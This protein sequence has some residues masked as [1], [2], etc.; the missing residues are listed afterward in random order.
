MI[1]TTGYYGHQ[2]EALKAL[3]AALDATVVDIRFMPASRVPGWR[4][5]ALQKLLGEWKKL[6]EYNL[7]QVQEAYTALGQLVDAANGDAYRLVNIRIDLLATN[8]PPEAK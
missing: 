2:P 7:T 5:Q 8:Q 6:S 1:Y 3:A 4:K